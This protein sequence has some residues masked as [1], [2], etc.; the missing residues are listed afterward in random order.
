MKRSCTKE[1]TKITYNPTTQRQPHFGVVYDLFY[2]HIYTFLTK[3]GSYYI[4]HS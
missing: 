2:A 3:V 4:C 1:K